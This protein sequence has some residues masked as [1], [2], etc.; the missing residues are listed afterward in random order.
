[1]KESG[2]GQSVTNM[3]QSAL[4]SSSKGTQVR[5]AR[6][7]RVFKAYKAFAA[8]S[9]LFLLLYLQ[10]VSVISDS[11]QSGFPCASPARP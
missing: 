3:E 9:M 8:S 10:E 5:S 6:C 2:K 7:V 4:G 1:M 11:I